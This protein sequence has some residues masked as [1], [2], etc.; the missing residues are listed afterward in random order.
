MGTGELEVL[1][2]VILFIVVSLVVGAVILLKPISS[3][4]GHLLEA[5]ARERGE[6]QLGSEVKQLRERLE[7][8]E[9]RLSLLEERQGFVEA[10]VGERDRK[11]LVEP[12][13]ASDA[14]EDG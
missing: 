11:R 12:E 5:M 4:L 7:T 13:G 10:L 2:P 1:G 6:P 3:R 8:I 9:G 14:P